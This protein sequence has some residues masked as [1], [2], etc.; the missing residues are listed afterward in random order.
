MLKVGI[1][2]GIGSGKTTVCKVFEILGIPVFYAD[3]VAKQ[4]MV[5][6][7]ILVEGVKSAFGA[8]SYTAEGGLNNKHI[9]GIVF[10]NKAEL[11]K[12]NALVHPAVFRAFDEWEKTISPNV[13]YTLK[14]A[15]LLFESGSYKMCDINILVK[16]PLS[17]KIER[18]MQRDQATE[19]Q[20]LARMDKQL[21]DEQKT[22]MADYFIDNT[23]SSSIIL[24]V[25]ALHQQFLSL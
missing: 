9:A 8:E 10:E 24:Q 13:P 1:T 6:D 14:E 2:G 11:A 23:E 4:I 7:L 21:T 22:P 20:V 3:T 12:L 18:I 25:L 15:A 19:A 5:T 16:A 17:V